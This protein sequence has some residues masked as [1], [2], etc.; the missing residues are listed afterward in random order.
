MSA[1]M[2]VCDPLSHVTRVNRCDELHVEFMNTQREVGWMAGLET[3]VVETRDF[4]VPGEPEVAAAFV[5][6]VTLRPQ[7][8]VET[9]YNSG[10]A[11]PRE[12]KRI[13]GYL[14]PMQGLARYLHSIGYGHG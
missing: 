10:S 13:A 8:G 11:A 6:C 14:G 2:I 7:I 3:Q 1:R 12:S 9:L 5:T 4:S